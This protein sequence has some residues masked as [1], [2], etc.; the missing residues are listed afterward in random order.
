MGADNEQKRCENEKKFENWE[1]LDSGGRR[2]F[3]WVEGQYGWK[4]RYVK[5]V[6]AMEQTVRFY[7]KIFNEKGRLVEIHEK[8]PMDTGHK[9]V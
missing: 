6:D 3:Y 8:Y 2:Y 5:E 4:A 7:Q 9:K 1:E